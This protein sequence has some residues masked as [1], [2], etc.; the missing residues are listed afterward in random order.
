VYE[1]DL[2]RV[3]LPEGGLLA[4]LLSEPLPLVFNTGP[5]GSA[6]P[7]E[8]EP[9]AKKARLESDERAS[10]AAAA[11]SSPLA[12]G[13]AAAPS[14]S[15]LDTDGNAPGDA[16]APTQDEDAVP[17]PP[18]V[19]TVV[20]PPSDDAAADGEDAATSPSYSPPA[21]AAPAQCLDA[22][23]ANVDSDSDSDSDDDAATVARKKLLALQILLKFQEIEDRRLFDQVWEE[24]M[25]P[26]GLRTRYPLRFGFMLEKAMGPINPGYNGFGSYRSEEDRLWIEGLPDK[27]MLK[28][29]LIFQR[30]DVRRLV[31]ENLS[32]VEVP[33]KNSHYIEWNITHLLVPRGFDLVEVPGDNNCLFHA[34]VKGHTALNIPRKPASWRLRLNQGS[35]RKQCVDWVIENQP[36]FFLNE[37]PAPVDTDKDKETVAQY[38]IRMLEKQGWGGD[39]EIYAACAILKVQILVHQPSAQD[40]NSILRPRVYPDESSS[41]YV[42][43]LVY[44]GSN[45]YDLL[46]K[47]NNN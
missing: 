29:T 23:A 8:D 33:T 37:E 38:R 6:S 22:A 3:H 10:D 27:S 9:P 21:D 4:D 11:P 24:G 36:E 17:P 12:D 43:H 42:I 7:D 5:S 34:I 39:H 31:L 25:P 2:P 13:D 20:T 32:L 46:K 45:H 18:G 1:L 15:P 47:K 26:L 44:H 19:T 35:L 14:S 40:I 28:E 30:Y 16:V 41:T